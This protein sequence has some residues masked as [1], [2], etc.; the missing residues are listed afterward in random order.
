MYLASVHRSHSSLLCRV[1]S[2]MFKKAY[3]ASIIPSRVA[4]LL[5]LC[6]WKKEL[7]RQLSRQDSWGK[8]RAVKICA[9]LIFLQIKIVGMNCMV[10]P[11][12][13]LGICHMSLLHS[14]Q[15]W[16]LGMGQRVSTTCTMCGKRDSDVDTYGADCWSNGVGY[17]TYHNVQDAIADEE[18][19]C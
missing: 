19:T 5:L 11:T 17:Y 1:I 3:Q 8:Y 12:S 6:W 9:S 13:I 10:T 4:H 15:N 14:G 18:L 7:S 2:Y 16:P